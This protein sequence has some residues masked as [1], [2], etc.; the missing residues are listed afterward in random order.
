MRYAC[1]QIEEHHL[2]VLMAHF[3]S[4]VRSVVKKVGVIIAI[5]SAV[6]A[7]SR[8]FQIGLSPMVSTLIGAY[9]RVMSPV[10][11]VFALLP[12]KVP[13]LAVDAGVLYVALAAVSYRLLFPQCKID[14]LLYAEF[15]KVDALKHS[16]STILAP[17]PDTVIE[18]EWLAKETDFARNFPAIRLVAGTL[19]L[20]PI[21]LL[22]RHALQ[23]TIGV[24]QALEDIF[25]KRHGAIAMLGHVRFSNVDA[26]RKVW[27][28]SVRDAVAVPIGVML[29]FVEKAL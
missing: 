5:F 21:F 14:A 13:E 24:R 25:W 22:P 8:A 18:Y 6:A 12:I 11:E 28:D 26:L 1:R 7:I 27:R 16:G 29:F 2:V 17:Q 3:K 23:Y 9:R 19:F 10:Y 4:S 15:E 20:Y